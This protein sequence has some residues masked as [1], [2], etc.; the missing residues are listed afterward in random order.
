MSDADL[1]SQHLQRGGHRR[2]VWLEFRRELSFVSWVKKSSSA[3]EN[4]VKV[5]RRLRLFPGR[6]TEATC[7]TGEQDNKTIEDDSIAL[8][9]TKT[10]HERQ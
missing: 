7:T 9:Q 4:H 1:P 6:S 10:G 5:S 3:T 2:S 8:T